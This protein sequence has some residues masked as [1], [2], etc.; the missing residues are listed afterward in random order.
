MLV[1]KHLNIKESKSNRIGESADSI[2][3]NDRF[4]VKVSE[5]NRTQSAD[6]K[7][8]KPDGTYVDMALLVATLEAV[9]QDIASNFPAVYAVLSRKDVLFTDSPH[10]RTMATDGVSIFINPIFMELMLENC[11]AGAVEYIII[12]ECFHVLFDHCKQHEINETKYHD[13]YKVNCAQDYEINY[14]IEN[15]LFQGT[16]TPFK[17]MTEVAG[18]LINDDY[19]KEGLTWEEIYPLCPSRRFDIEKQSVPDEWKDGFKDGFNEI[20]KDL[21]KQNLIENL[22]IQ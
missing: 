18:G 21:R 1:F 3:S 2:A 8:L 5:I 14:V 13:G 9:E 6:A 7:Y 10:I 17:G 19:G 11:G 22:V 15:F 4:D 20:I 12:H 16:D